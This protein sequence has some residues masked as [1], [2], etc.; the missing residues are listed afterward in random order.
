MFYETDG[1]SKRFV[2]LKGF[3]TMSIG[4]ADAAFKHFRRVGLFLFRGKPGR[5]S[6]AKLLTKD[7]PRRIVR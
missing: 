7:E 1:A 4:V 6:A 5:G 3:N 2:A